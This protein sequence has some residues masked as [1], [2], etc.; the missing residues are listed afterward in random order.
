[1]RSDHGEYMLTVVFVTAMLGSDLFV[2]TLLFQQVFFGVLFGV[3]IAYLTIFL[4]RRVKFTVSQGETILI[5]SV[6][7]APN[8]HDKNPQFNWG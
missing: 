7:L 4:V 3:A 5:F 1:M 8:R 2:P 6:A